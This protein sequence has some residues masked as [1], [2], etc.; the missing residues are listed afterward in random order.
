MTGRTDPGTRNL[1]GLFFNTLPIR[2]KLDGDPD[3]AELVARAR[4]SAL[5]GYDHADV[6]LDLIVRE[7]RPPRLDGR[8]PLFQVVL[9]VV[10]DARGDAGLGGVEDEPMESPVQP[11]KLDFVLT[12]KDLDG[13]VNLELEYD[14]SRY[15]ESQMRALI[16]DMGALLRAGADPDTAAAKETG[17]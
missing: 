6:P 8:T 5:G 13:A 16:D 17:Q 2:L 1:I 14:A 15:T 3:F 10:D 7:V 4:E 9:N 12:A 11:S